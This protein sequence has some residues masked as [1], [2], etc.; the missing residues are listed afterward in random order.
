MSD[1]NEA[2][3]R[4]LALLALILCAV[5]AFAIAAFWYEPPALHVAQ[6]TAPAPMH[7]THE[8]TPPA[9]I[10]P[11]VV[12]D[13]PVAPF[14]PGDAPVALPVIVDPVTPSAPSHSDGCHDQH[15]FKVTH[16]RHHGH[17]HKRRRHH[18]HHR[19][20]AHHKPLHK[21]SHPKE[22]C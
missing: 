15:H 1:R 21:A 14:E 11:P 20:H 19:K 10:A 22:V 8:V 18:R 6:I 9:V 16:K 5:L 17:H 3:E 2:R 12:P 13:A 7:E 4:D